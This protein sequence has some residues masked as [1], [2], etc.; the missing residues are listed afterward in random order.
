[1]LRQPAPERQAETLIV[2]AEGDQV[3]VVAMLRHP[4]AFIPLAMSLGALAMIVWFVAAHGV[5]RQPDESGQARIWQ[6]LM[7]GQVP[8]IAYFALRWLPRAPRSARIVLVLQVGAA[9]LAAA[10]VLLLGF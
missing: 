6:L 1:V 2:V 4:S 3:T 7:A 10:P 8:V 9:I 5:V